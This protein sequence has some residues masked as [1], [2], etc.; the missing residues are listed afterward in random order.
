MDAL[1]RRCLRVARF[2]FFFFRFAPRC[3]IR[4]LLI[5]FTD[6]AMFGLSIPY[7]C[8]PEWMRLQGVRTTPSKRLHYHSIGAV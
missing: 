8:T 7:P 6:R 3:F 2:C 1:A 4:S 5:T